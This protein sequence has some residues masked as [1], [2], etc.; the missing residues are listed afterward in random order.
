MYRLAAF[1]LCT[2]IAFAQTNPFEVKPPA[3]VDAALRA[4]VA[5]FFDYQV[6]GTPRK[7]EVLVSEDSKDMY[8]S[9]PK[10]KFFNC[11]FSRVDYTDHFTKAKVLMVC[12]RNVMIP[13][14]STL[15]AKVPTPSN[16]RI[17]AGQWMYY[18][19]PQTLYPS[20]FGGFMKP[21]PDA[22]TAGAP[23]G[24]PI[25]SIETMTKA[26]LEQVR[27]DKTAVTLKEGQTVEVTISNGAPGAMKVL[28]PGNLF[29]IE[30]KMDTDTIE[31][32]GKIV[33]RLRAGKTAVSHIFNLEVAQTGQQ[34]PIRIN[35][36]KE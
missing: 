6:K 30:A 18:L 31:P 8:Y 5:E 15:K 25:P 34:L 11:E 35:V 13:G 2:S 9:D 17:E 4:R 7:A 10:P 27:V 3:Q 23:A 1:A 22:P 26:V 12:E 24:P 32:A 29:G 14:A 16:W 33:L 28:L 20:P 21:G 19:D 36:E